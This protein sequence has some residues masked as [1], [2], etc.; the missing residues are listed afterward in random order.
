M[1]NKTQE[2]KQFEIPP[3]GSLGLLALGAVGLRAWRQVRS[4]SDYEQKLIDRSKEMEKEMQK[5]MEE[6][7]V[8]QEEEKAKQQEIKNN[9][10]TNS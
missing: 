4:K 8:K 5:K 9:E 7:K 10:Q 6:R 3:E 1:D 2:L